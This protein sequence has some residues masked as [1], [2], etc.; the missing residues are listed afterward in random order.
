MNLETKTPA[1]N[2]SSVGPASIS[3][4]RMRGLDAI[5]YV[6]ALW[7]VFNHIGPAY[8]SMPQQAL[9]LRLATTLY[10]AGISGPAAVIVFFVISGL[11]IHFPYRNGAKIDYFSYYARRYVRIGVPLI[12]AVLLARYLTHDGSKSFSLASL[13]NSVL[14]S[15]VAELFY[16][17]LYPALMLLK[18]R[19]GWGILL[20]T[21]FAIAYL[22]IFSHPRLASEGF[23]PVF[24]W[25]LNWIL[26]LPC[27][28]LGCLLA[29]GLNSV[30]ARTSQR[31]K[32]EQSIWL[33]RGGI[34][35]A[36]CLTTLLQFHFHQHSVPL[37]YSVTLN[38]FAV[39]VYFWIRQ[40]IRHF[41]VYQPSRLLENAGASSYSLYLTHPIVIGIL[42]IYPFHLGTGTVKWCVIMIEIVAA[43]LVFYLLIERPSHLLARSFRP[44]RRTQID[45]LTVTLD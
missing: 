9:L 21:A 2:T 26:G 10:K 35:A 30:S 33:W 15:L 25:N 17:T 44:I 24:G 28:L 16:Y 40:E 5:R 4:Q 8:Q 43:S 12:A 14:W 37:G 45:P 34:W 27:W 42:G 23:Y 1:D 38:I 39:A 41:Q 20:L 3:I 11:C 22:V 6:C 36:S 13:N 7:V 18:K 32:P 19:V 31:P 29:E